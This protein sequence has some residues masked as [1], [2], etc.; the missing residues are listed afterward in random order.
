MIKKIFFTVIFVSSLVLILR[1]DLLKEL[2]G[3]F[4]GRP[5]LLFAPVMAGL[6]GWL[7]IV[8]KN[9]RAAFLSYLLTAGL[10]FSDFL[11]LLAAKLTG[12]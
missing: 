10:V 2:L 9:F 1:M 5:F 12:G 4:A 3:S 6:S 7:W 11:Y 8:E